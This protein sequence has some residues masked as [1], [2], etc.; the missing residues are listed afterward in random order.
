MAIFHFA[1]Q[2]ITRSD[3]GNAVAAAA[4]RAGMRFSCARTGLVFNSTRKRE[5]AYRA[6]LAPQGA[7]AWVFDR[8]QLWNQV[9]AIETRAN[10]QLAREVEVALPIELTHAQHIALLHGYV[11]EHFVSLGMVADIALHAKTG[12]PH[13]HILLTLRDV[14]AE[15]FGAKRRDWN[16]PALVQQ[17]R[18]AW[19]KSCNAALEQAGHAERIDHRSHKARGMDLPATVHQ[20]RRT[21]ANADRWDARAEFNAWVQTQ[22][23]LAKVRA[24]VER[25]QSQIVDLTSTLAQALAERNA[26]SAARESDRPTVSPTPRIW[27][28]SSDVPARDFSIAGLL[29]RRSFA[30]S[31]SRIPPYHRSTPQSEVSHDSDGFTQGDKPC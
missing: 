16:N 8:Q 6:I 27:T 17:W 15:G 18:E 21:P 24:Q 1:A 19:A 25:V 31:A 23:E 2:V 9:E 12:N 3:G 22:V 11:N 10:S 20:G 7:A 14:Q 4:Y 28:P 5:V 26:Q 30:G 29:A 13:A